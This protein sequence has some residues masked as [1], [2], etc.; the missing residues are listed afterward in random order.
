MEFAT[1]PPNQNVVC[2]KWTF[3]VKFNANG[4]IA[5]YKTKLV[6]KLISI[7]M[8]LAFVVNHILDIQHMDVKTIFKM[9]NLK[10]KSIWKY[11]KDYLKNTLVGGW[12]IS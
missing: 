7:W 5:K 11:L 8:L 2:H 4:T 10:K 6:V 12:F 1:L 9:V 3:K